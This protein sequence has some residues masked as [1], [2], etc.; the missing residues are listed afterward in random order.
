MHVEIA[1]TPCKA[2]RE[3]T[4]SRVTTCAG[5]D[6]ARH[7]PCPEQTITPNMDTPS[8][9]TDTVLVGFSTAEQP[10]TFHAHSSPVRRLHASLHNMVMTH[11]MSVVMEPLVTSS[12]CT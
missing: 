10:N 2:V 9:K 6:S 12:R 11:G 3:G 7:H 8:T 5:V 1:A 4:T